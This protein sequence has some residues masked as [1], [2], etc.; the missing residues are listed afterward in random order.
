M[1]TD[2]GHDGHSVKSGTL[3]HWVPSSALGGIEI[4][5]LTLIEASPSIRHVV[6]TGDA[7]GPAVALWRSA[8]AEVVEIV[9]WKSCLGLAWLLHW[10]AF[11]ASRRIRHLVVWSPTRLP[12]LLSALHLDCR[13]VVHLGN[14]G[15]F[16]KR[17]RWQD[18]IM[19]TV[20][21]PKSRPRLI[22]CSRAVADSFHAEPAF[23]AMT[24]EVVHNPVRPAFFEVGAS[25][26]A[27][28]SA[29]RTWGMLARLDRLKDH[30]TLIDAVKL[31]PP[32][33]DF[34]LEL[35]GGGA[36]NEQLRLRVNEAR[37]D[38]RIRFLG[39]V[40]HPQEAM[41]RW[42][43]FIF[44]TTPGEGFGIAVAE[45][46]AAGLPCVL[47]DLPALREVAGDSAYYAAPGSPQ[48]MCVRILEVI[49]DP[50]DAGERA[51]LGRK[52]ALGLFAAGT[53]AER[54]LSALG[55]AR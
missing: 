55:M 44:A 15:G 21:R 6:A 20:L 32:S 12:Q 11:V 40:S 39:P 25:R 10:R 23:A 19:G 3:V 34:R 42:E 33:L 1:K 31:L 17:A 54:Y 41:R 28:T 14:V 2:L 53:F 50:R 18:A 5:M 29:P 22:A 47:S 43:G 36:L 8:G 51:L 48:A 45:A 27:V 4:A 16:D 9:A 49:G 46:M 13:C 7:S 52:R 38:T 26:P 24:M 37:L 35:A 30:Q